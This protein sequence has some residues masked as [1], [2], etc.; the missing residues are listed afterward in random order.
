MDERKRRAL[1]EGGFANAAMLQQNPGNAANMQQ[2]PGA[3]NPLNLGGDGVGIRLTAG[4]APRMDVREDD[5]DRIRRW[6]EALEKYRKAKTHLDQR[7]VEAEDYWK[8]R[9]WRQIRGERVPGEPEPTSAWLVNTI[10]SKHSDAVDAYPEPN[11]LAREESDKMQAQQLS[12]I[13][14]VVLEQND[15]AQ[16][17]SDVWW[18]KLK[19]GTGVYGVFW[20][21][22]KNNGIGD[23]ALEKVDILNLFWEPGVKKIQDSRYLFYSHL[24]NKDELEDEYPQ[25]RGNL[26]GMPNA[27][28]KKYHYTDA[29]DTQ[30][31]AQVVDVYYKR[32][33]KLHFAKYTGEFLLYCTEDDPELA[34]RGLYDHGMYPFIFDPLFP[35]EGYP[36]CG[37]GYVDLIKDPQ[38]CVDILDNAFVQAAVANATPRWFIRADGGVNEEEYADMTKKFVHATGRLGDDSIRRIDEATLDGNTMAFK[39][40]KIQEIK[41]VSGNRDVNNGGKVAGV[42]AAS[43]IA[44]L[45]EAGNGLSRDMITS[46]YRAFRRMVEMCIELIRQFY[47]LPRWFRIVGP[48]AQEEY[49]RFTNAG[50]LPMA[51]GVPG[52]Q[53]PQFRLPV[54]DVK[55]AVASES[56]YT[57]QAQNQ[58]AEELFG[59]GAF[60]PQMAPQVLPMLDMMDFKGREELMARVQQNGDL[61]QQLQQVQAL[62]V[63]TMSLV[64]PVKAQGLAQTFGMQA[65]MPTGGVPAPSGGEK[66]VNR[67]G[68]EEHWQVSRARQEAEEGSVPR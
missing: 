39:D 15:F 29:I 41:E 45:Q 67:D 12:S 55:V 43:A 18:Y 46:A 10:L 54:F 57:K 21:A 62:L 17:W 14:P 27:L 51:Q 7:I 11:C 34:E 32:K 42:S 3:K 13:L 23:I 9:H 52:S 65:P 40:S 19:S 64:D 6:G 20:D 33:G 58:L 59:L 1:P 36:G 26:T 31:K 16:V 56:K 53:D 48:R 37:Y 24:R 49:I 8:Q 35:E 2:M 60:N 25:L 47:T 5:K 44:A 68:V 66:S 38:K 28:A 50:M 22:G 4:N 63:Q 61:W 30:D